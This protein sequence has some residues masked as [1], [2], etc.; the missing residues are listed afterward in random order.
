MRT[1]RR[2]DARQVRDRRPRRVRGSLRLRPGWPH[3]TIFRPIGTISY[4]GVTSP[5]EADSNPGMS[6]RES[7][8]RPD[9]LAAR[10]DALSALLTCRGHH[11]RHSLANLRPCA[12]PGTDARRDR[13]RDKFNGGSERI[14]DDNSRPR[15][16]RRDRGSRCNVVSAMRRGGTASSLL[17]CYRLCR[18]QG[19]PQH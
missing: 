6:K 18:S 11:S 14:D 12:A 16:Y 13:S 15:A 9:F 19:P 2:R 7:N 8:M 3:Q 5:R 1:C 17:P 10:R 4:M